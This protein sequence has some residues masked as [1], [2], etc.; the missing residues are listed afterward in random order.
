MLVFFDG[1]VGRKMSQMVLVLA[2]VLF[3]F[4]LDAA[5][6]KEGTLRTVASVWADAA[7]SHAASSCIE[8]RQQ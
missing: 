5:K 1:R 7:A 8:T 6:E 4:G 2:V 3:K